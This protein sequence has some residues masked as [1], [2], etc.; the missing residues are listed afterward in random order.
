M[1]QVLAGSPYV[2]RAAE[3]P[4]RC[5]Y[6]VEDPGLRLFCCDSSVP[7]RHD[8]ELGPTQL[9]WLDA[10]LD[11]DPDVPA[12]LAMYHHPV[13]SGIGPWTTSCCR[14]PARSRRSC[15]AIGR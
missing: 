9:A 7:G 1:L 10:E 3:E 14:M 6:R 4:E 15:S 2:Q 11:R 5:Y 13:A 8:G 12:I